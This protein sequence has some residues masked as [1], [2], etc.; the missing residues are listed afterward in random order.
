MMPKD[1]KC[2]DYVDFPIAEVSRPITPEAAPVPA[3]EQ[4]RLVVHT[5]LIRSDAGFAWR[6]YTQDGVS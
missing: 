6:N 2:L 3:G 1:H 5:L 4:A